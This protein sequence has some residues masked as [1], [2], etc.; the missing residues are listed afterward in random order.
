M[1]PFFFIG[2]GIYFLVSAKRSDLLSV[3]SGI[4]LGIA[5]GM[6]IEVG[7]VGLVFMGL[8]HYLA[9]PMRQWIGFVLATVFTVFLLIVQTL[10]AN[11]IPGSGEHGLLG[12]LEGDGLCR[13]A[14]EKKA[15]HYRTHMRTSLVQEVLELPRTAPE[16]FVVMPPDWG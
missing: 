3:L 2:L 1:P 16:V 15:E 7:I 11:E 12:D 10:M 8:C 14:E 9:V 6:R 13:E 4:C 5:I